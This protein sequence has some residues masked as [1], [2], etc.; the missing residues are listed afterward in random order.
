MQHFSY[1]GIRLAHFDAV[2]HVEFD[3]F[4]ER[5]IAG[6]QKWMQTKPQP[7]EGAYACHASIRDLT[8]TSAKRNASFAK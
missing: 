8:G 2:F 1:T 5:E 3:A 6:V 4:Y 7:K